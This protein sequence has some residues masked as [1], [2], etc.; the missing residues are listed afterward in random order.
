[1]GIVVVEVCDG[2]LINEMDIESI[3]ESEYPEVAVLI[4]ECL[5]FCGMCALRPYALVN[6][7]R[8]FGKTPEE[9]LQ[10]I[11]TKIEEELAIYAE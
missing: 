4:S 2:N 11:R 9:A 5:S 10:K 3:I 8:V 7:Q 1:M 6:N